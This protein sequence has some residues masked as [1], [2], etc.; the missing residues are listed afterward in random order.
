M[1]YKTRLLL[2]ALFIGL[3]KSQGINFGGGDSDDTKVDAKT[4]GGTDLRGLLASQLNRNPTTGQKQESRSGSLCCCTRSSICPNPN[5]GSG[6]GSS[7]GGSSG[8]GGFI[9]PRVDPNAKKE[10]KVET[11]PRSGLPEINVRIV[12]TN[13]STDNKHNNQNQQQRGCPSGARRCCYNSFND[14]NRVSSAC[15]PESTTGGGSSHSGG[16]G[17]PSSGGQRGNCGFEP[18]SQCGTRTPDFS[19]PAR[20]AQS[21]PNEYPWSCLVLKKNNDFVG[22]CAVVPDNRNNDVN[23]GV[24]RVIT[25]AHKLNGLDGT[26]LKI[27]FQE[28]DAR[29][30]QSSERR[31]HV[32][33]D[34]R[35]R[36]IRHPLF[37][38]S[39]L[40]ND[41]AVLFLQRRLS[42]TDNNNPGIRAACLPICRDMFPPGARC[43]V[44]GWGKNEAGSRGQFQFIQNKVT[45]P[46]V[47]ESRCESN[48]RTALRRVGKPDAHRFQLHRSEICAG[49]ERG[50]DA[51][52]G[53]GGAPLVCESNNGKWYAVGLVAWGIGC[54]E[55]NVPGVYVDIFDMMDFILN[56]FSF[57]R[58]Q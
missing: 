28:Y 5:R 38:S 48:L 25:A 2:L 23:R 32:E 45:V 20:G 43:E 11:D 30:H 10:D 13:P 57:G 12:N 47:S 3:V 18:R 53:D 19:V 49:G 24:D 15:F 56:P 37:N 21:R 29:G 1:M 50:K 7:G 55:S 26:E 31:Q 6:G 46:I 14:F 54:A 9:N 33:I 16:S 17:R 39:R 41:V 4:G 51:C 8:F 27:R 22:S 40:Q 58:N 52:E 35:G 42:V 34:V 44:A 36:F